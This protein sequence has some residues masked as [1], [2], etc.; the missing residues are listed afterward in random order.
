LERHVEDIE[1]RFDILF[2]ARGVLASNAPV[3][4]A[5]NSAAA[6]I[7]S[8]A[9]KRPF[10][11]GNYRTLPAEPCPDGFATPLKIFN[12]FRAVQHIVFR[13]NSDAR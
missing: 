13:P 8:S 12:V 9:E 10:C 7:D 1:A 4:H 5:T 3:P 6:I 2:A 11:L